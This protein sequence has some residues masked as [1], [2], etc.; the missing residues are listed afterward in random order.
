MSEAAHHIHAGGIYFI[1]FAATLYIVNVLL[2]LWTAR[3]AN[4]AF[5]QGLAFGF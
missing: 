3:H 2:G 4:N 1:T 5:A